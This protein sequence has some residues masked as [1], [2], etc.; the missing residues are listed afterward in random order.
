MNRE[1]DTDGE[2]QRSEWTMTGSGRLWQPAVSITRAATLCSTWEALNSEVDTSLDPILFCHLPKPCS[3]ELS[4]WSSPWQRTDS[5]NARI[6]RQ[7]TMPKSRPGICS[8]WKRWEHSSQRTIVRGEV[9]S[10]RTAQFPG[11]PLSGMTCGHIPLHTK[12]GWSY[13]TTSRGSRLIHLILTGYFV[14]ATNT[15]KTVLL[16]LNRVDHS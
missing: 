8:W 10:C 2:I 13:F 12:W 15:R 4:K 14:F 9:Q 1:R 6:R 11:Q 3:D 16:C 7:T 5:Q